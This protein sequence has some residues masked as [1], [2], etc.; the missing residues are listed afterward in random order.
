MG[1]RSVI[2]VFPPDHTGNGE[3]NMAPEP[4]VIDITGGNELQLK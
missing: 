3:G 2:M 4:Q 1:L